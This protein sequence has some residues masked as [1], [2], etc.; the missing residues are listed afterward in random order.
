[1]IHSYRNGA[2][3]G[4]R[5]PS[6]LTLPELVDWDWVIVPER[7]GN[8]FVIPELSRSGDF[9]I[10]F[11]MG[12]GSGANIIPSGPGW[13]LLARQ[14]G[15]ASSI[16]YGKFLDGSESTV[17]I[18]SSGL[19]GSIG[20]IIYRNV[21][22]V[23]ES[24]I[25]APGGSSSMLSAPLE[26]S[27]AGLGNM[28]LIMNGNNNSGDWPT[29]STIK[30]WRRDLTTRRWHNGGGIYVTHDP[31][32]WTR[33]IV[34]R[35][36][37]SSHSYVGIMFE[38]VKN[39]GFPEMD[40]F[41]G[42]ALSPQLVM[43]ESHGWNAG[44]LTI[45][46]DAEVGDMLILCSY[47][48]SATAVL[49]IGSSDDSRRE[50]WW[51]LGQEQNGNNLVQMQGMF[52]ED[53]HISSPS[54]TII[55]GTY[56]DQARVMMLVRGVDPHFPLA[57]SVETLY[58]SGQVVADPYIATNGTLTIGVAGGNR[59]AASPNMESTPGWDHVVEGNRWPP[60]A[61]GMVRGTYGGE[62]VSGL[63]WQIKGGTTSLGEIVE[64]RGKS[65][66]SL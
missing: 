2:I 21:S 17:S 50:E 35:S 53:R 23:Y 24:V 55:T 30:G 26:W 19:T 33:D 16:A 65:K 57:H 36:R 18:S 10:A 22:N 27:E 14:V 1:M 61:A 34:S 45:P 63:G 29:D 11:G 49:N 41:L 6:S 43:M 31:R 28:A 56:S 13:D 40:R 7:N 44:L 9:I 8:E 32:T 39:Y 59:G 46:D 4:H 52:I 15:S 51:G 12:T 37:F 62:R 47:S 42:Q 60:F 25:Q 3:A 54:S 5:L 64:L 58:G 66:Y 38:G 48:L 20:V